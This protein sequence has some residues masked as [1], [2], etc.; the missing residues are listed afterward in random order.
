MGFGCRFDS[1][2]ARLF[3]F[4]PLDQCSR[5]VGMRRAFMGDFA[6]QRYSKGSL[7]IFY[8]ITA[9]V[10]FAH[11]V[12]AFALTTLNHNGQRAKLNLYHSGS[13]T[14]SRV[15]SGYDALLVY[16]ALCRKLIGVHRRVV[17]RFV[18]SDALHCF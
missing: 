5:L 4:L 6:F 2:R 1:G 7:A 11:T 10:L 3:L 15:W 12:R 17:C 14:R 9:G 8:H 16:G 18:C 13:S